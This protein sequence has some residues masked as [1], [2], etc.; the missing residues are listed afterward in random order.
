MASPSRVSEV[1]LLRQVNDK[2]LESKIQKME[3][4]V[5]VHHFKRDVIGWILTFI[6]IITITGINYFSVFVQIT[7]TN[8]FCIL[9]NFHAF[10]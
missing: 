8:E 2:K 5:F 4:V 7:G 3:V 1:N 9:V 10:G 6:M